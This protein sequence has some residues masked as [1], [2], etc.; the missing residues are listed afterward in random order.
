MPGSL[1][2]REHATIGDMGTGPLSAS[3]T[4]N[5]ISESAALAAGYY[6]LHDTRIANE[7]RLIK[8]GRPPLVFKANGEGTYS[9]PIS[10][11]KSHFPVSYE[12]ASHATDVDRSQMIFTRQQ[13]ARAE[14]YRAH[15]ATCLA[16]VHD[17]RVIAALENGTLTDVP[18]T[19]ADIRNVMVIH[20]PCQACIRAKGTKHRKTGHYPHQPTAPGEFLAGDL[21]TIMGVLF[22]LITCRM[23]NLR[24]VTRIKNKS[25]SQIMSA[26]GQ[27]LGVW[28]GFGAS[29]KVISWDQ[30]PALVASAHE[31]WAKHGVQMDFTPPEGHEKVAERNVR[32]VKEHVYATILQLGHAIDDVMLE[33]IVRDTVTLL[34]F[35]PSTEVDRSSPRTIIDGERLNYR[36]WSRFSA[37]Q[38]GEFEIPY[39]DKSTGARKEL[40]YILCHQGDNAVV[41]LLP[42]GRR[43]VVRSAH[44]TPLEKSPAIIKLIGRSSTTC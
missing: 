17:D 27:A 21:F 19:P 23:V 25:A 20:G 11:F 12:A 1:E 36:R 15:H 33:G 8:E 7:Y 18:Y 38:V 29:P 2:V 16:H 40:G 37:G 39:R 28:K 34:N 4:R 43:A 35:L 9:M 24:I 42:S 10:E 22:Y 26:T 32:T 5:L 6:V 13:R 3:F 44:F 14:L 31:I 30:E 41:R